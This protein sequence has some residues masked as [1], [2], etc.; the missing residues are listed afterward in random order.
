LKS[1]RLSS[2]EIEEIKVTHCLKLRWIAESR[3]KT[4]KIDADKLAKLL[5]AGLMPEI[6]V[7]DKG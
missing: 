2:F 3:I 4:D 5:K 1:K 6:Y 7:P